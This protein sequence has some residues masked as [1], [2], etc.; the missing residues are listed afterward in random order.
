MDRDVEL[1]IEGRLLMPGGLT[2]G[3]VGISEGRIV[4]VKKVLEGDTHYDFTNHLIVP[5]AV[6]MH[7]HFR[8]PGD[9]RKG[10]FESE[11]RAA[12]F[13]GVTAVGDMP[14][15]SPP[16]IDGRSWSSKL[17]D[18]TGSSFVDLV[19][20]MGLTAGRDPRELGQWTGLFKLYIASSTGDLL[21]RDEREWIILIAS[22][23]EA[24]GRVVVHAEDQGA[25]ETAEPTGEELEWH[26]TA[27]PPLGEARAVQAV[28]RVA[29]STGTP[30]SVHIAHVS[31][32]E[33]LAALGT[34]GV[35]VEVA[36]HHLFLDIRREDLRAFGKVN[37]PLRTDADRAAL[38]AAL[39]DGRIAIMSSDHA[40]HTQEEK[41]WRF[42]DAP[43]GIPG[44]ET[45]VPMAM[46]EARNGRLSLERLFDAAAVRPAA[47]LGL[48][49]RGIEVGLEAHL[50]V[51]DPKG[52]R[53]IVADELHHRCGYTPYE[54]MLANFP[55]F[56]VGPSGVLVHD[57]VLQMSRPA[58]RYVGSTLEELAV[59]G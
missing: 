42:E 5:A 58:G 39:A 49:R 38:W 7:V 29:V 8:Q 50:A 30:G 25:I 37:P 46:V 40:P 36:P 53:K 24:G 59:Q 3:C 26:H 11:S 15:N 9:A 17:A 16:A 45:M 54:G 48:E 32:K 57:G 14:N 52:E 55:R 31:C 12:A 28:G 19:A 21:V 22:A 34:T 18:V 13:G 33:A 56:V 43:S 2:D 23:A 47:F 27:R 35:S 10:T 51:Y 4:A 1:S 6:D 44:V 41:S 20:Y